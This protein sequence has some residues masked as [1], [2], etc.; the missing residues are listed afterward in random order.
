[1]HRLPDALLKRRRGRASASLSANR[2]RLLAQVYHH[3]RSGRKHAFRREYRTP[4]IGARWAAAKLS[5]PEATA[6]R[7]AADGFSARAAV[8]AADGR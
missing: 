2:D 7:P 8:P 6:L 3:L 1:M 5:P 4:L